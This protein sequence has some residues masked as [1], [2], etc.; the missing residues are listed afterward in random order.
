[1]SSPLSTKSAPADPDRAELYLKPLAHWL[2]TEPIAAALLAASTLLVA[3]F[4]CALPLFHYTT[5]TVLRWGLNAWSQGE[6]AH[7][8]LVPLISLF[9]LW[10]DRKLL[11]EARKT[12]SNRGLFFIFSGLAIFLLSVRCLECRFALLS[13]PFLIYGSVLFLLGGE[14]ARVF[15]VPC[16]LLLFMI[17]WAAAE[18]A[19]SR[20][21]FIITGVVGALANI[22]GISTQAIGTTL[23]AGDGSF[24]FEIA[25]GCSG[26]HSITAITL[27]TAVFVHLTQSGFWKKALIFA[28]SAAFAVLGNIA[29]IFSILIVAKFLGSQAATTW[30]EYAGFISFPMALGGMLAF[31]ALLNF[32]FK[33]LSSTPPPDEK[34]SYDY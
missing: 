33:Q 10:H 17:P 20:L 34:V 28:S 23:R 4:F 27:L 22:S 1:M 26:V 7:G 14:V 15:R 21:Q 12:G 16:A 13:I 3:Y 24:N 18:Q 9:L 29:R 2:K 25:D 19:T 8:K 5:E 30:H 31:S 32:N 6:Q 11:L